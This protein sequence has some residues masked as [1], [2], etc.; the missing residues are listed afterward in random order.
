MRSFPVCPAGTDGPRPT[1][2]PGGRMGDVAHC[3]NGFAHDAGL[4]HMDVANAHPG[5]GA[6]LTATVIQ[7]S[8][9]PILITRT[10][11]HAPTLQPPNT[12][13]KTLIRL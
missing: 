11:S 4:L 8:K 7:T 2:P 1:L 5:S 3:T 12:T 13:P 10:V 9:Q 6:A